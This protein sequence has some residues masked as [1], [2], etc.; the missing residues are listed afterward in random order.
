MLA[1][2]SLIVVF[3]LTFMNGY[4]QKVRIKKGIILVDRNPIG[5]IKSHKEKKEDSKVDRY[6]MIFDNNGD[7]VFNFRE[8]YVNS[9]LYHSDKKYF[10]KTVEE[11]KNGKKAYIDK[12]GY[13]HSRKQIAKLLVDY[14]LM[15]GDGVN[16]VAVKKYITDQKDI[17][18]HILNTL[19]KEQE[20]LEYAG[21]KVDRVIGDPV[22][23]FFDRTIADR[24][25]VIRGRVTKSI[26]NIFQGIK[27]E[28]TNEFVSKVFIGYAI[29]EA[30]IMGK[31]QIGWSVNPP[32]NYRPHPKSS[33]SL[34]L[35][36]TKNV[37]LASY[38]FLTY[39]HYH[40]YKEFGITETKLSRLR[41]IEEKILYMTTDLIQR[42][43][44]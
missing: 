41:T 20:I 36:N 26:Y 4:T 33:Y 40:P 12:S 31:E 8:E 35:Y 24:G 22:F 9:V 14:Q 28:K 39:K 3:F 13:Y 44:L 6:V 34:I 11:V 16:P 38:I 2:R 7:H 32:K 23:V 10:Y 1:P 21:F 18:P 27:D 15:N 42:N 37:P 5:Q 17:P 29:A 25:D 19:D 43:M 30:G